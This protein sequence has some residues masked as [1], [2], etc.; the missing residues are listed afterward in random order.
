MQLTS[1]VITRS[2][3]TQRPEGQAFPVMFVGDIQYAGVGD[4]KV[5]KENLK[6]G[7]DIGAW[8]LGM[9]DYV[10]T[11]SPSN[12][13]R[14][15]SANLYD[16]ALDTIDAKN[17]DLVLALYE[18]ALKP[19]KGRWL[20][21]VAGH[22]W[23]QFKHGDT[24]DMRLAAMLDTEFFGDSAI[25]RLVFE[26]KKPTRPTARLA[27]DAGGA[28]IPATIWVHHGVGNGQTNYYPL[29]RLEKVA[30]TWEEIDVFAMGHT[31]KEA[32]GAGNKLR[33]R[34]NR[35]EP[36]LTHRKVV[37]IGAGGY[38]KTYV[39]NAMQGQVRAGG[40]AE[41]GMMAP[42][43]MGSPVAWFWPKRTGERLSLDI[44]GET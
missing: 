35:T 25:I 30:A 22:H 17:L 24:T 28:R 27:K 16:T 6:R 31:C 21:L 12:R 8:F 15:A 20:G 14:L 1:R 39:E 38:S 13:A 23:H 44:T 36:D 37:L 10:D 9:G 19:T 34:W 4:L 7:L 42:A 2:M 43:I 11:F 29:A 3:L 18:E 41:K 5:L 32:V 26:M 40:Y 33:P